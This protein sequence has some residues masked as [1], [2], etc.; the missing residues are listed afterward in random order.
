MKICP[1]AGRCGGCDHMGIP[2]EEQL[3]EKKRYVR[4][5]FPKNR[6]EDVVGMAD[7][8]GY[9]HKVYAAFGKDRKG[10]IRAG[11][12]EENSHRLVHVK[13]CMIQH[14]AANAII[15]DICRIASKMGIEVYNEDRGTGVL[16]HVYIR[17]SHALPEIMVV[18]VIGSKD[19]PGSKNFTAKLLECHPEITTVILNRNSR[20]TGM[21]LGEDV[22]ILYGK[23]TIRDEIDG[24]SFRI[25][26]HSFYQV[27]PVQTLNLY[28]TALELADLNKDNTVLDACCGI[29][30]ISLL[31]ARGAGHVT[32]IE[33][34]NAAVRDAA[35]NAKQNG[36][37]NVSFYCADEKRFLRESEEKFDVIIMDPP[38]SGMSAEFLNSVDSGKIVYI[39]CNPETQKR[40]TD[41]LIKRG[42]R[43]RKIIPFDMF[44]YTKHVETIVLLQK[45]NS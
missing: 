2:Y 28:R 40:D 32:G 11:I 14:P 8:S 18:I 3:A 27:N 24:I 15:Q 38:R 21:I 4:K 19:L 43:I 13:D 6:V 45:L 10:N 25:S 12:Y 44:P 34:V 20:R 7:P 29:G 5:L 22:K 31:A 39:S 9:R 17:V 35:Y 37:T 41:I 42:Y 1:Y 30:T 33:I 16:R 23:G 26:S 36:I